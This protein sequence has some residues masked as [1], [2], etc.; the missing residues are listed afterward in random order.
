MI[1]KLLKIAPSS[2]LIITIQKLVQHGVTYSLQ[3]DISKVIFLIKNADY[4]DENCFSQA[5][6][7][8]SLVKKGP[9]R[10][11]LNELAKLNNHINFLHTRQLELLEDAPT[12]QQISFKLKESLIKD[13]LDKIHHNYNEFHILT[14]KTDEALQISEVKHYLPNAKDNIA[15]LVDDLSPLIS[16]AEL[17]DEEREIIAPE[18]DE[19]LIDP[20]LFDIGIAEEDSK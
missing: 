11:Y 8:N 13:E 14:F 3:E 20:A 15:H 7:P 4:F 9:R 18:I 6:L 17:T 5:S 1:V 10:T 2:D 16:G 12:S 19:I